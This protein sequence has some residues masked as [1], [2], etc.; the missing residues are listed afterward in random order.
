MSD[1]S[2]SARLVDILLV[3]DNPGDIRLVQKAFEKAKLKNRLHV[4]QEGREALDYLYKR[5]DH[6]DAGPIDL[7]LLDL[8]LKDCD[9]L[10]VLE[11]IKEDPD[12]KRIPVVVLTSSSAEEDIVSS[13]DLHANAYLTKPVDFNG[14]LTIVRELDDFWLSLVKFAPHPNKPK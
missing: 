6:A 10:E 1:I 11:V 5:G 9:G 4:F 8:K 2:K 7:I 14:L 3:E 13:Y 12:L